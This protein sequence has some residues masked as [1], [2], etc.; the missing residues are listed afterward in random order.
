MKLLLVDD[1]RLVLAM[2]GSLL[3]AADFSVIECETAEQA[4]AQWQSQTFDLL[5]TDYRMPGATGI[6]LAQSIRQATNTVRPA[7]M[8]IAMTGGF[9]EE[10]AA[11]ANQLFDGVLTKPVNVSQIEKLIE[12]I[13]TS[14]A[15]RAN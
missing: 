1:D 9:D 14:S 15:I 13:Q 4:L 7:P 8:M 10:S 5:I 3:R 11:L 12:K 2:L 6:E